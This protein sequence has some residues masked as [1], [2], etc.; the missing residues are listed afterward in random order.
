M[1]S[2]PDKKGRLRLVCQRGNCMD[3]VTIGKP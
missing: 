1:I 3:R 2:P